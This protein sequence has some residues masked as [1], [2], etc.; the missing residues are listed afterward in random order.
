VLQ[1]YKIEGIN[2]GEQLVYEGLMR[3]GHQKSEKADFL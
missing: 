3:D 2:N 1:L